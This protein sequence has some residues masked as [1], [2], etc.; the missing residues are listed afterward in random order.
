[1]E[2]RLSKPDSRVCPKCNGDMAPGTLRERTQYGGSSPY[3]WAPV[4]D[5]PFPLK[6]APTRRRDITVYRCEQCG[7]LEMY[8][9]STA[10]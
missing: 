3:V 2:E 6:G 1:M 4:D 10:S 5:V 9:P 7:Y 8:A